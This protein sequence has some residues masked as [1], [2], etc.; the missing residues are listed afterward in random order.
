MMDE[1]YVTATLA[2]RARGERSSFFRF[3]L[4]PWYRSE[5]LRVCCATIIN[6]FNDGLRLFDTLNLRISENRH[7]SATADTF[8]GKGWGGWE[9]QRMDKKEEK[10][11]KVSSRKIQIVTNSQIS[12]AISL[13]G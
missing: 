13:T 1:V 8:L 9:K 6:F 11:V 10:R 3:P 4:L 2:D 7:H 5:W 12:V